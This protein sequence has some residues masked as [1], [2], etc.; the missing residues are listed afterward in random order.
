MRND[1]SLNYNTSMSKVQNFK[2]F[3]ENIRKE[4]DD[5]KK[6][7]RGFKNNKDNF[8]NLPNTDSDKL[9]Y[10]KITHKTDNN[11]GKELV[12]DFIDNLDEIED[13][14]HKYKLEKTQDK[15]K[16]ESYQDFIQKKNLGEK[17]FSDD[18]HVTSYM[19]FGNLKTIHRLCQEILELEE[20]KV[21]QILDD[22]HNWAE[23]HVTT[24]KVQISQVYNFLT[25]KSDQTNQ[26]AV[27]EDHQYNYMF[28]SNLEI[29]KEQCE[30]MLSM[31]EKSVDD[32]LKNGHDWAEDHISSAKENIE[33]VHDF[34][35]NEF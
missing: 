17:D 7:K 21:N 26:M 5:L 24:A 33:Q 19:F 35:T 25:N 11:F 18:S 28:F 32:T 22:G 34:L 20:F 13:D 14:G 15:A 31:D 1:S 4:K 23:D 8:Y 2:D 10:N 3:E 30:K 27:R 12:D 6:V 29:I 9:K 16:M